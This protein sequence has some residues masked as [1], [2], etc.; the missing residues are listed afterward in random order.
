GVRCPCARERGEGGGVGESGRLAQAQPLYVAPSLAYVPLPVMPGFAIVASWPVRFLGVHLW[1]L[2]L[3]AS[4]STLA[5]AWL[6]GAAVRRETD[7]R[8]LGMVAAGLWLGSFAA[9]S[10]RFDLARPD[11]WS[12]AWAIAGLFTLRFSRGAAGAAGAALLMTVAL[13]SSLLTSTFAMAALVHLAVNDRPRLA[14]YTLTLAV[15]VSG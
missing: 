9:T 7:H 1:I 4:I 15:L 3:L 14:A 6:V 10:A 2:R 13:F 11:T 8:F 5:I 12:W